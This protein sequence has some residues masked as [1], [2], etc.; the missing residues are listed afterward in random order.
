MTPEALQNE[1]EAAVAIM[2]S[3]MAK[4]HKQHVI[5]AQFRH[6]A[7]MTLLSSKFYGH[8]LE[9]LIEKSMALLSAYDGKAVIEYSAPFISDTFRDTLFA[10][11]CEL[12]T[13]DGDL[14]PSESEAVGLAA[15][16]L[17]ISIEQMRGMLATFLIRNK[18]N[19]G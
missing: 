8:A 13:T 19:I 17:N 1:Q 6:L 12:M 16:H 18:W 2:L 9:P 14:N 5:D 3:C 10:M 15:L 7:R 4:Q 11:I